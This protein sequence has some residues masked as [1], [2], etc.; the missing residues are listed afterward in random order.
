MGPAWPGVP[1]LRAKELSASTAPFRL[2]P[3]G[4]LLPYLTELPVPRKAP[5]V[6]LVVLA[7]V[8]RRGGLSDS[9]SGSSRASSCD[10]GGSASPFVSHVRSSVSAGSGRRW[11][12]CSTVAV[13][14][15]WRFSVVRRRAW[16]LRRRWWA[17]GGDGAPRS[18]RDLPGGRD[19]WL[20]ALIRFAITALGAGM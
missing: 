9:R 18:Y 17:R 4:V 10:F 13:V 16:S 14:E 7:E 20:I 6:R 3:A 12:P 2:S 8:F 1:E 15:L 11:Q 19:V 5:V